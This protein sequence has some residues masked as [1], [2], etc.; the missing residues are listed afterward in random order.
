MELKYINPFVRFSRVLSIRENTIFPEYCPIDARLFFVEN[1]EGKIKVDDKIFVMPQNSLLFINSGQN[2]HHMPCNAVYNAINFDFTQNFSHFEEPIPP[3]NIKITSDKRPF[4][5]IT[6]TD[7]PQ[8]DKYCFLQNRY[9]LHQHFIK[10]NDAY[11]KKLP[12]YRLNT[13]IELS[14]ILLK[15]AQEAEKRTQKIDGFNV[16]KV[17]DYIQ[18]HYCEEINNTE[19]SA[20]FHFHPNS[21]NSEFK[22]HTGKSLHSYI[23]ELRI[24]KSIAMMESG[25][26]NIAEIAHS[27]GFSD[28]NY[29]SRYF[30]KKTGVNPE[31]CVKSLR[32]LQDDI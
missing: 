1:G 6:F 3:V 5:K 22:K 13:S 28:S 8:F 15:I 24:L 16:E 12:F 11:E 21:I 20:M 7:A 14:Y 10:I 25:F 32:N 31:F 23:L 26:T 9:S 18:N 2:Y 27:C 4:E 17:I 29:F 19:L 30:K